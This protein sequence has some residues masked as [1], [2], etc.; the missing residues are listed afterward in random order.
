M[1]RLEQAA[2]R[3][4]PAVVDA[5][6]P[7]APV[8]NTTFG[9]ADPLLTLYSVY[10]AFHDIQASDFNMHQQYGG[11]MQL[12]NTSSYNTSQIDSLGIKIQQK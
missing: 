11:T 5:W 7:L 6:E 12:F 2:G 1:Q 4:L 3:Y 10:N 8:L 9:I